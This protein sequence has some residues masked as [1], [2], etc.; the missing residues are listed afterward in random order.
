MMKAKENRRGISLIVLIITI[1]V[2]IILAT[3]IILTLSKNNPVE[4]AKEATFKEDVRTF[5]DELAMSV[6]KKYANVGGNWDGSITAITYEEILNYIP[7]FSKKYEEKF[8][9]TNN[10]LVYTNKLD[11]KE[12][13]YAQGLNVNSLL[14]KEFRQVEYIESTG[15][16]WI[17]TKILASNYPDICIEIK[18][19]YTT[20]MNTDYQFVV[21]ANGKDGPWIF[22]GYSKKYNSFIAQC[23]GHQKEEIFSKKDTNALSILFIRLSK[24]RVSDAFVLNANNS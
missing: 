2:V 24:S 3:V 21:G 10:S 14:P 1:I 19:N 13:E 22:I 5:Q 23:A 15:K 12:K 7:S 4:S 9:I 18:G 17:D 20:I 6:S 16:Q 8:V 11:K